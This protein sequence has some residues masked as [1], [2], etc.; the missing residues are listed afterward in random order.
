MLSCAGSKGLLSFL[1]IDGQYLSPKLGPNL[2]LVPQAEMSCAVGASGF[3]LRLS[4]TLKSQRT[5]SDRPSTFVS[6]AHCDK[7]KRVVIY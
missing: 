4:S 5:P 6:S 7:I 3:I 2:D 1:I